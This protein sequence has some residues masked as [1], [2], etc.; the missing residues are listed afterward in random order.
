MLNK[1]TRQRVDFAVWCDTGVMPTPR[2][3]E[4]KPSR[5][6][7]ADSPNSPRPLA[8]EG[9]S[10]AFHEIPQPVGNLVEPERHNDPVGDHG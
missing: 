6:D 1:Q 8:V 9:S 10:S 4:Q 5:A 3:H 2:I 7:R